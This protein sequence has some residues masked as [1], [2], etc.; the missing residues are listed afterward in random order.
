MNITLSADKTL[1]QKARLYAKRQNTTLNNLVREFL[2]SITGHADIN[3]AADEF[4]DIAMK[5]A[6]KSDENFKF[7]RDG[8]YK[9]DSK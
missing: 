3:K 9:R 2:V 5:Y 7:S 6:G 1:I 4:E 8:I